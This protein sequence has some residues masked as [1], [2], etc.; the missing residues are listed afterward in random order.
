MKD[1]SVQNPS[2]T[3]VQELVYHEIR[4]NLMVGTFVPGQKVSLRYLAEQMGT[5]LTPV[6]GAVNRLLAEGA[7]QSLPN[8]SV[9][10]PHMTAQKFDEIVHWRVLLETDAIRRAV[11]NMSSATMGQ[12]EHINEQMLLTADKNNGRKDLLSFNYDFHFLIY[13]QADSKVLLPMIES[14]WLQCGPFTYYSLLSPKELW[15]TKHHVKIIEALR[16]RDPEEAADALR[17][18]I[19]STAE[20]LRHNGHYQQSTLRKLLA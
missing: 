16:K 13:Q 12:I 7:F 17:N 6:R 20:F 3:A 8:R 2:R 4:Q 19:V 11:S 15:D 14:L 18:D 1:S 10:I 5:S 9:I